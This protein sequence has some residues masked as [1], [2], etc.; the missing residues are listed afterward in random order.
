MSDIVFTAVPNVDM[1]FTEVFLT[2]RGADHISIGHRDIGGVVHT[3]VRSAI[4]QT[5]HVVAST[6]ARRLVYYSAQI[7]NYQGHPM[8]VIVEREAGGRGKIITAT[9]KDEV[10]GTLVW[11]SENGLYVNFDD[12]SDILYVSRGSSEMAYA[13]EDKTEANV[14]YRFSE[15]TGNHVG[16]TL[17]DARKETTRERIILLI[18]EFLGL[19]DVH[20]AKRISSAMQGN[21]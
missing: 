4:E 3:L 14:W 13:S 6:V 11:D 20:V 18:A 12:D 15:E 21:V 2:A 19:A 5:T 8:A 7:T 16:V 10:N 1:G 9:W 17:F